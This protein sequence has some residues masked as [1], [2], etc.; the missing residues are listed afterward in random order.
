MK[1]VALG[2]L[3]VLALGGC[4][5]DKVV[6]V[7]D[8]TPPAAPRGLASVTGD[9]AVYLSWLSN[10]EADVAAYKLY[11]S[12]CASGPGC[13]YDWVL[14][15][16]STAATIGGLA[17]GATRFFAVA[18][19]DRA[20]NESDLSYEDVHDTPRPEG[21]ALTLGAAS[22][23]STLAGLDF[24][25]YGTGAFR[26]PWDGPNV[27]VF[28]DVVGGEHVMYAAYTDTD[29]QDAG[30]AASLDAVDWAPTGGWSPDGTV[31]LIPGHNYVVWTHDDHYA[32]FRVLTVGGPAGRITIDWAYQIAPGNPELSGRRARSE[33]PRVRRAFGP[34][35]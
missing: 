29:I 12:T 24:S 17:N 14:T 2:L 27:D 1:R 5:D 7:R 11:V 22:A 33:G 25:A 6:A 8:T 32:K 23:E 10:T 16:A 15:T 18:A 13:P 4:R 30:Y 9:G 31:Q 3:A 19:V 20:G 35:T 28:H 34:R 21:F 26:Q